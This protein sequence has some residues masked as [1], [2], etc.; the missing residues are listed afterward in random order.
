MSSNT[1]STPEQNFVEHFAE[2]GNS[3]AAAQEAGTSP[4]RAAQMAATLLREPRIQQALHELARLNG[5]GAAEAKLRLSHWARG[6]V[7]PFLRVGEKGQ[8]C[9][10]LSTEEAKANY[11]LLHRVVERRYTIQTEQGP[12]EV[13]ET[14]IELY[15]AM[16]AVHRILQLHGSYPPLQYDITTNGQQ[17]PGPVTIYTTAGAEA[18]TASSATST[19]SVYDP[20]K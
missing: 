18:L 11:H 19:S 12:A 16:E 17:L 13:V 15:N 10:D 6:T 14:E 3:T 1:L 2:H 4:D 7:A 5:V 20:Q 8:V 9:V